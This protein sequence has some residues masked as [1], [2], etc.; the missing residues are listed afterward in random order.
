MFM[1]VDFNEKENDEGSPDKKKAKNLNENGE[2]SMGAAEFSSWIKDK[3]N[4]PEEK[5]KK[6]EEF[7]LLLKIGMRYKF[8]DG[9]KIKTAEDQILRRLILVTK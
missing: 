5:Q 7:E 8:Y 3:M 1:L 9:K 4:L 2:K 6:I